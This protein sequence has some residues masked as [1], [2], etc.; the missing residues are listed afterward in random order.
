MTME[1]KDAGELTGIGSPRNSSLDSARS[2]V[3]ARSTSLGDVPEHGAFAIGDDEDDEDGSVVESNQ[4]ISTPLSASSAAV[5]DAV[6]M[7]TRSMSE[8]ARGKQPVGQSHFS[9]T[10]SQNTSTTSLTA[11]NTHILSSTSQS[12]VPT[13]PWVRYLRRPNWFQYTDLLSYSSIPGCLTYRCTPFSMSVKMPITPPATPPRP[14]RPCPPPPP[15]NTP[16]TP[17]KVRNHPSLL[18]CAYLKPRN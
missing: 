11:L 10:N 1:K 8:K 12:F 5:E 2:P 3:S 18:K 4:G 6:P 7:Q 17:K 13:Q 9:R 15:P 16:V 14:I